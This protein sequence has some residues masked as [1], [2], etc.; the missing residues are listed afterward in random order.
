MLLCRRKPLLNQLEFLLRCG[1]ASLRLLLKSVQ[2]VYRILE[3]N[4]VDDP[5]G[6]ALMTRDDFKNGAPAE[7]FEALTEEYSSPHCA[8]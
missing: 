8:A 3:T 2:H 7:F 6:L 1:N 5:P 4:R